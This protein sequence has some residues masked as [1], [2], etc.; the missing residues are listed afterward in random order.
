ME[1]QLYAC[2]D[3]KNYSN[4]GAHG[5]MEA[6]G[7][8]EKERP[9]F[10]EVA[11]FALSD[12]GVIRSGFLSLDNADIWGQF[13]VVGG[14]SYA[15]SVV[16]VASPYEMPRAPTMPPFQAVTTKNISQTCHVPWGKTSPS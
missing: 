2:H 5:G 12:Q 15:L 9:S 16:S 10:V 3:A 7:N 8:M 11:G 14:L 4:L 6:G 1:G 13:F